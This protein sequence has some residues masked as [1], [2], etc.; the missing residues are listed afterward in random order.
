MGKFFRFER[1]IT[2][3]IIQ[4][5]FWVGFLGAILVGLFLMI[6]SLIGDGGFGG[7]LTGLIILLLGPIG[8]R[9]YCEILIVAF[10]LLGLLVDVRDRIS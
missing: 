4:V 10:K 1:M 5:L 7:V 9:I 6:T 2:P 8:V 3:L